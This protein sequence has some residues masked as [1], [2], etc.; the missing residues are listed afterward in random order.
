MKDRVREALLKL[1]LIGDPVDHSASPALHRA[2]LEAAS[3]A[4][5][6]EAIRIVA[7]DAA[8]AIDALREAGY[9]GLN[10]TTPLK[11]EAYAR[12][13]LRDPIARATGAVNTLVLGSPIAGYNTDGVGTL[14]ALAAAGL[15]DV[16]GAHVLVLGAG[17]TAR[18]AVASLAASGAVV[19]LWN[20]TQAKAD[21][22][23]RDLGARPWSP[24]SARYPT[25]AAV[26]SALAPYAAIDNDALRAAIRAAPIVIDANYG[27]R[28][29]LGATIER[30][31]VRDGAAMLATSARASFEIFAS[32]AGD[33]RSS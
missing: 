22:I 32:L 33:V 5:T 23:V 16:A 15:H 14:G 13:E 21:A 26:F 10:V 6:Y 18:A 25:L 31:D 11:E 19:Q 20:R 27:E 28:A 24:T 17:P 8:R 7:G 9:R 3:R 1:A 4:G 2:F 30:S 29:T 12:A